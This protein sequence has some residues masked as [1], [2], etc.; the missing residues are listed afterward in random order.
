M[1]KG[2][3]ALRLEVVEGPQAGLGLDLEGPVIVGRSS[4]RATF[5]LKDS[6]ASRR[7]ASLI[8]QGQ[9]VNVQDL[10]ST[11][12]TFV[13]DERIDERR[14]VGVGDRLRIGTSVIEV[15]PGPGFEEPAT[16]AAEEEPAPAD[17]EPATEDEAEAEL[18]TQVEP[19]VEAEAAVAEAEPEPAEPEPE[20]VAE[21]DPTAEEL[22]AE[23]VEGEPDVPADEPAAEAAVAEEP[24]PPE[25]EAAD[26]AAEPVVEAEE[27]PEPEPEPEPE[28]EDTGETAAEDGA[29]DRSAEEAA[30]LAAITAAV[31]AGELAKRLH[32]RLQES[33]SDVLHAWSNRDPDLMRPY[34]S[35]AHLERA[36]AAADQLDRE[37]QV[38]YIKALD[39]RDV[40]VRRPP[41]D[42]PGGPVEVYLSFVA[43]DWIEDLRT[44]EVLEGDSSELQAFTERWTFVREGR[45]G[46]VIDFVESMWTGPAE[47]T[48][49]E[50]WLGLPPGSY[51]RR[52]RPATWR[53]WDGVEWDAV[54]APTG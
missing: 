17:A 48:D 41:D 29:P 52:A 44:G 40:A 54:P 4:A 43:R 18:E 1:S 20:P 10:G 6:E 36:R 47:G 13:N 14:M 21:A 49:P 39:L 25:A 7:H 11:N 37:Y 34:V 15:Q 33:F 31:E 27:E 45:R 8:P 30:A 2:S 3:S 22:E 5:V 24:E 50:D 38:N 16:A 35:Q 51:T 12:G 46:W 26:E 23:P 42:R 53:Q 9:S 32:G 19:A 28:E